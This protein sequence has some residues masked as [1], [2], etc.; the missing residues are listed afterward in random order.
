MGRQ[1]IILPVVFDTHKRFNE[2]CQHDGHSMLKTFDFDC[3]IK[4]VV[5]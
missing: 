5:E 3:L 4:R 1:D 2:I